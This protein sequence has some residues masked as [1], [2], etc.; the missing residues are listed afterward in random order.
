MLHGRGAGDQED[1][2]RTVQQPCQRHLHRRSL[3]LR[4][5]FRKGGGTAAARNRPAGRRARRRSLR[6]PVR[7]PRASSSRCARLYWFCT[8]TTGAI[9]CACFTCFEVAL[10]RPRWRISPCSRSLARTL[11]CGSIEPSLGA[12]DV[13]HDAVVDHVDGLDTEVLQVVVDRAG[14]CFRRDGRVPRA[15]LAAPGADLGDDHEVVRIGMQRLA[16]DLVGDMGTVE[17]AGVDM[18]DPHLD[19]LAQHGQGGVPRPSAA[20]TRRARRAA[21][22]RSPFG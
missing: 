16:D 5:H 19:G 3:Q 20:R 4:R 1:I 13:T 12:W 11:N 22:R 9:S 8:Q 17:V 21:S 18:V 15:V 7:P 6:P 10:L 14:Q 2:G